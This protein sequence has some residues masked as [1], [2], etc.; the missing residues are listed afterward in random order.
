MVDYSDLIARQENGA[1]AEAD[2]WRGVPGFERHY[3]VSSGGKIR[4]CLTGK[5][6]FGEIDRDGYR[7][8]NLSRDGKTVKRR[9]H[10]LVCEAFHGPP[11]AGQEVCHLDGSR[12]HNTAA[13][14]AWG[15]RSENVRQSQGHGTF[16][17]DTSAATLVSAAKDRR[18]SK[19]PN[20][21]LTA[22]QVSQM[23]LMAAEGC[24]ERVI[25]RAI[26]CSPATAHRVVSGERHGG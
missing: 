22:E 26:G 15:T 5:V 17:G 11:M 19:N 13:N 21:K 2:E 18:G 24:S 10:R 9:V 4:N 7:R 25:A 6:L 8:V 14:L 20:A 3:V 16:I 12:L 23:K 1:S